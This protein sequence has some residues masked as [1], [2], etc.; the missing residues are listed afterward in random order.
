M[1]MKAIK[2]ANDETPW[3]Q[4]QAINQNLTNILATLKAALATG[5]PST[6]VSPSMQTLV[7]LQLAEFLMDPSKVLALI[8]M[9]NPSNCD[10]TPLVVELEL[11]SGETVVFNEV[12][13]YAQ[14]DISTGGLLVCDTPGVISMVIS[15]DQK[16]RFAISNG[17]WQDS[18]P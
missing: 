12:P 1:V 5:A 2:D 9:A 4:L 18:I 3:G 8:E 13:P 10:T 6:Q 15:F 11:S 14:V 7:N 17:A 16:P